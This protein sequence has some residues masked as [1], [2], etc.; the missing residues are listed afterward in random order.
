M[1]IAKIILLF[2]VFSTSCISQPESTVDRAPKHDIWDALLAENVTEDGL[3]NYKG[4]VENKDKLDEYLARLSNNAPN[5]EAWSI[6]EQLAYWINAYN[7]FTVKLIVDNYPVESIKD[8][9]PV[10]I[11]FISSVW[12]KKFFKIA[13]E[14]M[15]LDH[16]EHGILR[17][18]FNEP[19]IHFAINCASISCPVLLN[20]AYVPEKIEEQLQRQAVNFI[21]DPERNQIGSNEVK[22]SKIFSWFK[23]DF[24]KEKI[25][26]DYINQYSK[27]VVGRGVDIGYLDYDWKLNEGEN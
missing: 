11:P 4:F 22:L 2:L 18:E 26:I 16:I 17:K 20:E 15:N 6:E 13:G 27:T 14:K 8:L 12:H 9:H 21:N 10:N 19:R 7:A 1:K 25:L 24:T 23:G 3:T 5:P